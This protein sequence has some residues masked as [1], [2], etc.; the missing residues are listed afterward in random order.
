MDV[1]LDW[2]DQKHQQV[3]WKLEMEDKEHQ[4]VR[5][6]LEREDKDLRWG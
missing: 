2:K 3:E 6:R 5:C 4:Q 1:W